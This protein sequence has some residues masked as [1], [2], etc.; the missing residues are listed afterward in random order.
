VG[1]PAAARR[2]F[3]SQGYVPASAEQRMVWRTS[4]PEYHRNLVNGCDILVKHL[5]LP[6]KRPW[7]FF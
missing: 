6:A 3:F 7:G 2:L 1:D 5:P 4:L